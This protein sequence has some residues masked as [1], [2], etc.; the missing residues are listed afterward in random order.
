MVASE[1]DRYLTNAAF[2][3]RC[4]PVLVTQQARLTW[5]RGITVKQSDVSK[6]RQLFLKTMTQ[7][8][9]CSSM[10]RHPKQPADH[11]LLKLHDT[12]SLAEFNTTRTQNNWKNKQCSPLT[13]SLP[14]AWLCHTVHWSSPPHRSSTLHLLHPMQ[15]RLLTR[16]RFGNHLP[17]QHCSGRLLIHQ[18]LEDHQK[19]QHHSPEQLQ[20]I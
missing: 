9:Y 20:Q 8:L 17:A 5:T 1:A 4:K 16:Q 15:H 2:L 11:P 19:A 10:V 12:T 13:P 14:A 6:H 3:N 7:K 18:A